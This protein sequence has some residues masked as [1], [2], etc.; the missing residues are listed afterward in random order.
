MPIVEEAPPIVPVVS[1]EPVFDGH[2]DER[3]FA[4]PAVRPYSNPLTGAGA[5][6]SYT[7][8]KFLRR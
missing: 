4:T 2:H 6:M 8:K 5:A 1:R 7:A 3:H